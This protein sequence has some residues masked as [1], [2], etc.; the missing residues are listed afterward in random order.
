MQRGSVES[1]GSMPVL[2]PARVLASR[3]SFNPNTYGIN[4]EHAYG[5]KTPVNTRLVV[6]GQFDP[7]RSPSPNSFTGLQ[8]P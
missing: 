5:R 1:L 8:I 7:W 6:N 3:Q 4:V 2:I